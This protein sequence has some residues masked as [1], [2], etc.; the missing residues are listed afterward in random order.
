MN[1]RLENKFKNLTN[2]LNRLREVLENKDT[3]FSIKRD[4]TIQRFEF[5]IELFWKFLKVYMEEMGVNGDSIKFPRDILVKSYENGLITDEKVWINMMFDR[6]KTSHIY[7]EEEANKI[8]YS[9]EN[10]YFPI[11]R[12]DY[13][14][15][16]GKLELL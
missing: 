2:A 7:D 16:K 4:S 8:Y 15:I 13:E 11:M 1:E 3:E 9:I 10:D 5:T 14:L 12:D 6:N